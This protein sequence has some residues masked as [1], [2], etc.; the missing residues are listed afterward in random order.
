MKWAD[1]CYYEGEFE[2]SFISGKGIY[3]W[4]D[5]RIFSGNWSENRMHGYG[6]F[7]W[8]DGRKYEGNYFNDKKHG[9]GKY[10][11]T[12]EVYY[13][14]NWVNAKQHGI[15]VCYT[16]DRVIKGEFRSGRMVRII[17]EEKLK[18]VEEKEKEIGNIEQME[19][20][21]KIGMFNEN[22]D[23]NYANKNDIKIK[24]Y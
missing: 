2:N 3:Y 10:Y 18:D 11:W 24:P 5:G 13:E 6:T 12:P 14:G 21:N 20:I 4:A 7:L 23:N 22:D 19:I 16:N 1:N 8:P 9:F 15:G 17:S